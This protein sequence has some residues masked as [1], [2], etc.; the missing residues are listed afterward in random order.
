MA[1]W[2][3]AAAWAT[4]GGDAAILAFAGHEHGDCRIAAFLSDDNLGNDNG[5]DL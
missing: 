4:C 1:I 3:G 2:A 5:G